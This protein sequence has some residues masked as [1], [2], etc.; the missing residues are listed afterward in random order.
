MQRLRQIATEM[1]ANPV[2][3]FLRSILHA[4]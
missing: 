3:E 4:A 2:H 1:R